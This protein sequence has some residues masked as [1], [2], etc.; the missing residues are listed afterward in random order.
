VL[1]WAHTLTSTLVEATHGDVLLVDV[2]GHESRN[3]ATLAVT[4]PLTQ[5][6][7]T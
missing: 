6:A 4:A 7:H 2:T 3:L 5:H 1:P